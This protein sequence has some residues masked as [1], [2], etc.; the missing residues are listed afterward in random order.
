M[1]FHSLRGKDER[2]PL[3]P[4]ART[5]MGDV[6]DHCNT[7]VEDLDTMLSL[8]EKLINMIF[9]LIAYDTNESMR[10]L[11]LVP[12]IF[13][14]ITFLAAIVGEWFYDRWKAKS[15]EK[16]PKRKDPVT[17]GP[18]VMVFATAGLYISDAMEERLD[19]ARRPAKAS[20]P[21]SSSST[22]ASDNGVSK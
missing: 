8:C 20:T 15:V 17:V 21:S 16:R 11:A 7:M 3:T 18:S 12:I 2:S 5:Y 4:L 22:A 9:N 1:L 6:M 19:P 14:P 13:L 10:R